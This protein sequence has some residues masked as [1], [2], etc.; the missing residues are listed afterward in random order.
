MTSLSMKNN[1]VEKY[2]EFIYYFISLRYIFGVGVSTKELPLDICKL[3]GNE[4]M[5]NLVIAKNKYALN[6]FEKL[7]E[8]LNF[9]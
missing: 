7:S 6:Y 5:Q 1:T 4:M 8:L 2:K 3:I 9:K